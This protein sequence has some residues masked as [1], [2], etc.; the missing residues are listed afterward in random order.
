MCCCVA[1]W[2]VA[3]PAHLS[4][5]PGESWESRGNVLVPPLLAG[6]VHAWEGCAGTHKASALLRPVQNLHL[7]TSTHTIPPE[8]LFLRTSTSTSKQPN[9][10]ARQHPEAPTCSESRP[11]GAIQ[12]LQELYTGALGQLVGGCG[13]TAPGREGDA[14]RPGGMPHLPPT[15]QHSRHHWGPFPSPREV[16]AGLQDAAGSPPVESPPPL[17][18]ASAPPPA[19]PF[20]Q[21]PTY[22]P[23]LP[24]PSSPQEPH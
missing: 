20:A 4:P 5:L 1:C 12:G 16:E 15:A 6:G 11:C 17:L 13:C 24:L 14:R 10:I 23:R 9:T 7:V 3:A 8:T 19:C 18:T 21:A 2:P 22:P